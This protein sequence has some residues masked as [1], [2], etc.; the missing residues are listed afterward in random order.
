MTSFLH[1][2]VRKAVLQLFEGL[3]SPVALKAALLLRYE[4]WDQ[5]ASLRVEPRHYLDADSYWRDATAASILRKMVDMPTSVDRK[6]AAVATFHQCEREC[7]RANTRLYPYLFIPRDAKVGV[8]GYINRSRK[9][10]ADILGPCPDLIEGRFGPGS[11]YGDRGRF[12]TIPDKMSSQP[13]LTSEAWAFHFP[14]TSTLWAKACAAKDRKVSFVRGNR[15]TSVPKD[16][17]KDRGIA[18]EPSINVFF[19]LGYG[20]RIRSRLKDAGVN[21]RFGQ[22]IHRRVVREASL[23]GHLASIDLSNAS[24]T[25]CRN[26]VKLLLPPR[27]FLVLDDLRSKRTELEGKW[28]LCEKFSSMGNG[29][30]FELETLI[31]LGLILALDVG[32]SQKL[33]PGRNVFVFGDDIVVPTECSQDVISALSFFGMTVNRRKTFVDGPFRESCG[34]DFFLGVD[35]RPFF[36]KESPNEPQQL[37]SMANGLRRLAKGAP[38]RMAVIR[39]AWF[40]VLDALPSHIRNLRG[41]EDLGDLCVHDDESRWRFRWRWQIRYFQVYKPARFRKVSWQNFGPEVTLAAAVYGVPWNDGWIIQRDS[42]AG[43]ALG[44]VPY[45]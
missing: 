20:K 3:A 9:I 35:V 10:I 44:W 42:V 41:P 22:D 1:H 28:Y 6:A 23:R 17:E 21:L 13:T 40:S 12:S 30:T 19:Q 16:A 32:S 26:L 15:F 7:L 24:D 39:R 2:Q 31:F 5:L 25:I 34:G 33:V 36:L 18:I 11:T 37:I 29:F 38:D 43:Y 27:W 45:S 14:W 4:E 8:E